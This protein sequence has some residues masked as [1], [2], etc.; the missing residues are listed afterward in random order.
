LGELN[1]LPQVSVSYAR[2]G[3][4]SQPNLR[5]QHGPNPQPNL[6]YLAL[7]IHWHAG[8]RECFAEGVS[9][10]DNQGRLIAYTSYF[11]LPYQRLADAAI[12]YVAMYEALSAV[13]L[14]VADGPPKEVP[15]ALPASRI[16]VA[17]E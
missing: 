10:R 3:L 15:I 7:A 9:P 8:E 1:T 12:G 6:S 11:C 5:P 16:P 4:S 14:T 13:N 17:D 2:H